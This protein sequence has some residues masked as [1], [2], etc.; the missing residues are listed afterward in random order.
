MLLLDQS[1]DLLIHHD[2]DDGTAPYCH[3]WLF[4]DSHP[5]DYSSLDFK[6]TKTA[7]SRGRNEMCVRILL[8]QRLQETGDTH[9]W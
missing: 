8:T 7:K 9:G 2:H 5:M 4:N 3:H 6:Y 1:K